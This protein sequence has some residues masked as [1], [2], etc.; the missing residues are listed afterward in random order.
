[1]LQFPYPRVSIHPKGVRSML[2][3]GLLAVGTFGLAMVVLVCVLQPAQERLESAQVAYDT[4]RQ[5]YMRV[6]TARETSKG[7]Q[8][9]WRLLPARE[10]FASLIMTISETA[11]QDRVAI[12]G[13]TYTFHELEGESAIQ[14]SMSFRAA[15]VYEAIR[16]FIYRLETAELYLAIESLDATRSNKANEV[17]FNVRMVTYLKPSYSL[18]KS[19]T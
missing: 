7:L 4:A 17:E 13:M 19:G 1:M 8:A 3:L 14:A 12:P 9:I 15:G 6:K 11:Q 2:P 18:K 10:E 16:R 5:A